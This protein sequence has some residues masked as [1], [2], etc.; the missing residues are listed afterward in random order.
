MLLWS[1]VLHDVH[2]KLTPCRCRVQIKRMPCSGK[3]FTL[4]ATLLKW[5]K[6]PYQFLANSG[7][8][9]ALGDVGLRLWE[10]LPK[11]TNLNMGFVKNHVK[12]IFRGLWQL[13]LWLR[14][15]LQQMTGATAAAPPS[16]GLT[17]DLSNPSP[18]TFTG[19]SG[20]GDYSAFY[21]S[22]S[23]GLVQRSSAAATGGGGTAGRGGHGGA[24]LW[25]SRP[26]PE[27]KKAD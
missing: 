17:G 2:L 6:Y 24:D 12:T 16:P 3:L 7:L 4:F 19:T 15:K 25:Q 5:M 11:R 8:G 13:I 9:A 14:D 26:W 1:A 21:S 10:A 22:Q 27:Q 23:A 20:A 18:G